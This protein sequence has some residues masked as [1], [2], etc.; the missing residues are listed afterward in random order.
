M[1]SI[2]CTHL[3]RGEVAQLGVRALYGSLLDDA[4]SGRLP[5]TQIVGTQTV[6][7]VEHAPKTNRTLFYYKHYNH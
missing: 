1:K 3:R 5:I 2:K 6:L 7:P 4:V